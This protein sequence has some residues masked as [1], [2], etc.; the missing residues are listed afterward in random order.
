MRKRMLFFVNPKAGQ[1]ELRTHLLD[2]L[3][4]FTAG[5]YD[6]TVHATQC[7]RD[8]TNQIM[9][10]GSQFDMIAC[11][12][13]DGTLNEAVSG[14]M[15]LEKRPPLGY[16][17][18]GTVNDVAATLGLSKNPI[19]AAKTIVT[20]RPYTIDIGSFG[21]DRWF[22]YVAGF[23]MFTDVAYETPQQDKRIFGRLAYLANGARSLAGVKPIPM[24][25][26]VNGKVIEDNVL[27]GLV[28]STTSVGGFHTKAVQGI[29]LNDGLSEVVVVKN[30][31]TPSDL[32]AIGTLLLKREFDPRFFYTFQ[33]DRVHFDFP[34]PVKWTLDGEFGGSM[35]SVEI[36]NHARSVDIIVPQPAPERPAQAEDTIRTFAPPL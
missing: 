13:G 3:D 14:L 25:M 11:G 15:A 18:G 31:S 32:N 9:L 35:T 4:I 26:C 22:T 17:P 6:V 7:P 20:G 21:A 16:I 33:T 29:S 12:G 34:V 30:I 27:L 19:E 2:I 5:G 1:L 8:I 36:Q 28:C 24:R 23:G 10:R